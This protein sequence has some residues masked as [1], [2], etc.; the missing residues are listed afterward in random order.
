M[1]REEVI[2]EITDIAVELNLTFEDAAMEM[3]YQFYDAAGL[4]KGQVE[5]ELEEMSTEQLVN[6]VIDLYS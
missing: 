1:T 6:A 4:N 5:A 3:L 2:Q